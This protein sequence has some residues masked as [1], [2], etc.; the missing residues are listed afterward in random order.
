MKYS[1]HSEISQNVKYNN[2]QLTP[3]PLEAAPPKV[4]M[5]NKRFQL[6]HQYSTCFTICAI[7]AFSLL[8]SSNLSA[9]KPGN[10]IPKYTPPQ[11]GFWETLYDLFIPH[12]EKRNVIYEKE[13]EFLKITVEDDES[14]KRHLVFHPN[15]GS[16][17]VIFPDN[18]DKIVPNF[19]KYAFLAFPLLKHSPENILFI[20][21]G[22]GIMPKFI[23][24]YYRK[25][26]I[27]IVE[28]DKAVPP[29]AEKYFAFKK[30]SNINIII[31]DGRFYVNRSRKKYDLIVI[32]AYNATSIPFQLT[33]KEFFTKVKALLKRGGI[34]IA[35]IANLGNKNFIASEFKTVESLFPNIGVVICPR[36]TNYVLFASD[37]ITFENKRWI[38]KS[39]I[40][41]K[42]Q[43]WHFK[44]KPFLESQMTRQSLIKMTENQK[45]LT[46]DS[47]PVNSMD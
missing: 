28:I 25:S 32:D 12:Y 13:S 8:Y 33:T 10:H 4:K 42:Q 46:D 24:H 11:K 38:K 45:I 22:A 7:F 6:S 14:G 43:N 30:N 18:P 27:D 36:E 16:Q 5:Q 20:G 41:D 23:N 9:A 17:G 35:N 40:F 44:L 1:Q 21:M 31:E 19:L 3:A 34:V 26:R 29:I 39:E 2:K 47:A 37:S 15:K